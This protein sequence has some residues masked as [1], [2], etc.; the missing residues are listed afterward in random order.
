MKLVDDS[1]LFEPNMNYCVTSIRQRLIIYGWRCR[2]FNLP[3]FKALWIYNTINGNSR[4]YP[5]PDK[6]NETTINSSIC[7]MGDKVYIVG[8]T[9]R[10]FRD[11]KTN[12]L[13]SFDISDSSWKEL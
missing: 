9:G 1:I 6:S 4:R 12:Y 2:Q 3:N 10:P 11:G 8:G 13:V 7:T 5:A